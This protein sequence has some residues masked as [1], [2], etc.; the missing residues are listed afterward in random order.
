MIAPTISQYIEKRYS[1]WADYASY[2]SSL[3]G[4][5]EDAG[6]ILNE[7]LLS[8][9]QK[10]PAR[11][12]RMLQKR[13]DGYTELDFFILKMIKLNSHSMTS[14]WR[15]K[16]NDLPSDENVDPWFLEVEDQEYEEEDPNEIIVQRFNRIRE[17]LAALDFPDRDKQIFTWKFL[18]GNPLSSW[19][20]PEGYTMV[21]TIFNQVKAKV[22]HSLRMSNQDQVTRLAIRLL[23]AVIH[24]RNEE[25]RNKDLR[26][27]KFTKVFLSV[28]PVLQG[29]A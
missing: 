26:I 28:R 20:G 19:P 6:D 14:P 12:Q 8:L 1:R 16:A 2:H 21:C 15:H 9:L 13:K 11:L 4:I 27:R 22:E 23:K 24:E 5:S 3:A 10:D 29:V 17:V 7:V 18:A 25:L